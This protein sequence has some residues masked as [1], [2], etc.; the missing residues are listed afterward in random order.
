MTH[1]CDLEALSECTGVP[2]ELI[3]ECVDLYDKFF[4]NP[5]GWFIPA[6]GEL[7][8]MKNVPA[9]YHGTG[10]FLR[11]ALFGSNEYAKRIPRMAWLVNKWHR[12]LYSMLEAELAVK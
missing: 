3:P 9:V 7:R 2:R 12:A 11:D 10:A 4:P 8:M 1:P 5:K 6:K